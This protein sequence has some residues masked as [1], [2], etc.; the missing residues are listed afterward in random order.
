MTGVT[1][2]ITTG[3]TNDQM[4]NTVIDSI[5]S[6]EL[7]HYEIIIVGGSTTTVDRRNTWHMPFDETVKAHITLHGHPGRWTTRKKNLGIIAARY[8]IVIPMHDYIKIN[9]GWK[10]G[11]LSY[12]FDWDICN[13]QCLLSNGVRA[14]GWRINQFPGLPRYCMIPYDIDIFVPYM[15][16]QGNYWAAKKSTMIQY[17]LDENLLWG[18]EEDAEW[19]RRVIPNCK[20]K[21]NADCVVQYLKPRPDDPNHSIDVNTM[22]SLEQYW[23]AI[24]ISQTKYYKLCRE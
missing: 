3:G 1:F 23:H 20:I 17:P 16:I 19:S 2:I 5:E 4:I 14:D 24:R 6:E 7:D 22:N 10:K 11:F 15:M 8:D 12:G 13:H 9:P 18:M 21:M